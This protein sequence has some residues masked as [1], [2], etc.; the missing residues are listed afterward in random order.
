MT[1]PVPF[2]RAA[3]AACLLAASAPLGAPAHAQTAPGGQP[4]P[5]LDVSTITCDAFVKGDQAFIGNMLMWLTGYYASENEEP[6]IDFARMERHGQQLGEFCRANPTV[7]LITA[8]E[9]I[10]SR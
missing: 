4:P 1:R 10:M 5:P 6:I 8:A 3:I 9:R 2:L 7:G